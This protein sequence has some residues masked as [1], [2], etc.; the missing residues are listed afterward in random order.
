MSKSPAPIAL[1]IAPNA[2]GADLTFTPIDWAAAAIIA[3]A[4]A[5]IGS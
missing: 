3:P 5:R 4:E 1:V 2:V